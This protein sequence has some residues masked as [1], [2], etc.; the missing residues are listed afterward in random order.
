MEELLARLKKNYSKRQTLAKKYHLEAF[1]LYH[2]DLPNYPYIV[3]LY[4]DELIIWEKGLRSAD[5]KLREAHREH[6]IT[7]LK[8]LIPQNKQIHFKERHPQGKEHQY[9]KFNR[10]QEYRAIRE[11]NFQF[12]VNLTDYLDTGLFLDHRILRQK[13]FQESAGKRVLNLFAYTGSISVAAAMGRAREVVSVDLSKTYLEWAERNFQLNSLSGNF[14]FINADVLTFLKETPLHPTFDLIICDPPTFSNSKKTAKD[15]DVQE[16]QVELIEGLMRLLS[17]Q[18][19]LYFSNNHKSFKLD[20]TLK[21]KFKIQDISAA[22][23]PFDFVQS[24]VHHA[25]KIT[26]SP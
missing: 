13:V 22:T 8:Q 6:L 1:R 11:D 14:S 3:D 17:P 12:W 2:R 4:G 7:A 19:V 24:K 5:T 20:S 23:T 18:G 10:R 25:Y 16:D 9:S 21:E 26:F 15:F